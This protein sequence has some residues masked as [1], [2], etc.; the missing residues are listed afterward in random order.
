MYHSITFGDKNTWDDWHL[1]PSSRPVFNPPSVK[2]KTLDIPGGD[3]VIDLTE[4]LTGYPVYNNRSGSIEFIVL[5]DF[6]QPVDTHEEWYETYSK[7]MDY[8][9]G[10]EMK[11]I[12]DD[13]KEYYYEGRFTVNSWKSDKNYSKITIDYSVGPYKW[14]IRSI[15][16]DWLW[17]PFNFETGIIPQNVFKSIAVTAVNTAFTFDKSLFGRAPVCPTFTVST[18]QNAGVKIR[19]INSKLDIDYTTT[20]SDGTTQVPEIVFLGD[21]VTIY[22]QCVIPDDTYSNLLDSSGN[23]ILDSSGNAII[24]QALSEVTGTVS[25]D[26]KQGRL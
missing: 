16:D 9:H 10:Q 22:L 3:G 20:L 5:N 8:L 25:I 21:T 11:A 15:L 7:I 6:C 19:F 17:D 4:S 13:D 26:F 18:T 12:L 24:G 2:T 14:L 1:V 23:T